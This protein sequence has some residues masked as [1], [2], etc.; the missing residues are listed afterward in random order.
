M[1]KRANSY[2][3]FFLFV[4]GMLLSAI[5]ISLFYSSND[6]ITTGSNGLAIIINYYLNIDLSL[7][8]LCI[9]LIM[10][11]LSFLIFGVNYG[12]KAMLATITFPFFVSFSS[13]LNKVIVFENVSLFLL[14]V[15]GAII[16]GVGAGLVRKSG[17]NLGGFEVLYDIVCNKFKISYGTATLIV[18]SVVVILSVFVFG[19]N[20]S[21][22]AIIGIYI[23]GAVS[24]RVVL[25]ISSNKAFYIVTRKDKIIKE[26][27]T[28]NLG[29]NIT[30]IN[31]KGGY[32]DEKKKLL[33]CVI[34]TRLYTGLKEIV[35]EIDK[36][37]FFLVTDSYFVSK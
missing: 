33:L 20:K 27:L 10:L 32:S 2:Y 5:S 30:I 24:N 25:G 7:V 35:K 37:A 14:I 18:N 28:N 19:I 12:R 9:S 6:V 36:D 16:S 17:Y 8:I 4:M 13:L 15:T 22:Y 3:N 21:I 29:Y 1:N 31:A 34:P 23:K 26:Y 11:I